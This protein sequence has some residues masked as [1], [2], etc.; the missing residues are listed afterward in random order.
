MEREEKEDRGEENVEGRKGCAMGEREEREKE[1][2]GENVEGKGRL[3]RGSGKR[4]KGR[5]EENAE[6]RKG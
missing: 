1:S 6:G 3:T 5:D 4:K 2:G